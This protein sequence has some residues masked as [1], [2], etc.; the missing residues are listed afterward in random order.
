MPWL[1]AQWL[2]H[3][4]SDQGVLVG[5]PVKSTYLH[6]RFNPQREATNQCDSFSLPFLL[7]LPSTLSKK[8]PKN[9]KRMEKI[10]FSGEDFK[11]STFLG[12][13]PPFRVSLGGREPEVCIK[14]TFQV[15]AHESQEPI[16]P[17]ASARGACHFL[18][19]LPS[20]R[21]HR[22]GSLAGEGLCPLSFLMLT[23]RPAGPG[24]VPG[25]PVDPYLWGC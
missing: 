23:C 21:F 22:A 13:S 15:A 2:E 12:L 11:K 16:A 24:V 20:P 19:V 25:T 9:K 5:F 18:P 6:C 14:H 17:R 4:P 7:P 1:V 3:W 8:N 10:H